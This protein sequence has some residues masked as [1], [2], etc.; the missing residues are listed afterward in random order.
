[1]VQMQ[2]LTAS[3]GGPED[4][5]GRAVAL[6]GNMLVATRSGVAHVFRRFGRSWVE[7]QKLIPSDG[8]SGAFGVAADIRG[9]TIVIGDN[10]T[11]DWTNPVPGAVYI[12][13]WDGTKWVEQ[14]K[15]TLPEVTEGDYFGGSVKISADAIFVGADR[16]DTAG[17]DS[18]AVYMFVWNGIS[19]TEQQKLGASDA[20]AGDLFGCAVDVDGET[21]VIGAR[22]DDTDASNAG[23]AYVFGWNGASWI[24]QHKITGDGHYARFGSS[25]AVQAYT[26]IVGASYQTNAKGSGAGAA[27]IFSWD[28]GAWKL[29]TYLTA[30]NGT[31]YANFGDAVAVDGDGIVVGSPQPYT[32]I[33]P[34][35][36]RGNGAAYFFHRDGSSWAEQE[37]FHPTKVSPSD[38]F[39]AS[40]AMHGN[41]LIVGGDDGSRLGKA[42]IFR[43]DGTDWSP[44][45]KLAASDSD[46]NDNFGA[47]VAIHGG[48]AVV[49]AVD[50]E[51]VYVFCWDGEFWVEQAK[52]T[53]SDAA[54][55]G[56][57]GFGYSV[58]VDGDRIVVGTYG[59]VGAYVYGWDGVSWSEQ[60]K[61]SESVGGAVAINGD[62]IVVGDI[63]NSNENGD[64][65]GA[66]Y[67]F[68]WD[69]SA[70]I[71]EALLKASDGVGMQRFGGAMDIDGDTLLVGSNPYNDARFVYVFERDGSA[72]TER[73]KPTPVDD[74]FDYFHPSVSVSGNLFVVGA[75]G[76]GAAGEDMPGHAYVFEK[77]TTGYQTTILYASDGVAGDAFGSSVAVDGSRVAIGAKNNDKLNL[78]GAGAVYLFDAIPAGDVDGNGSIDLVDAILA[79]QITCGLTPDQPVH[80]A[81]DVSG[82]NHIGLAEAVYV[83]QRVSEFRME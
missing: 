77:S 76:W 45:Q 83:L 61:L 12:F 32:Y 82:E 8:G 34:I 35:V 20:A 27:Y 13:V 17:E 4:R 23:A 41:Q 24:E 73:D 53:S 72:W 30:S 29:H 75:D 28:G 67:V 57:V 80:H 36:Y 71:Q 10:G 14:Q 81:A 58:A 56:N 16:D 78:E 7:E 69:G 33:D 59:G 79:M 68:V 19:W 40:L 49:G 5:F 11:G 26:I 55:T 60:T 44:Q 66:A 65:A 74:S 31:N 3:D 70:W 18:G 2:K 52:L 15:L 39:G 37:C 64:R 38:G 21:L 25:V 63:W 46:V 51:A 48:R 9:D 62:T 6:D 22:G 47:S 54:Q 42:W 1:W 43:W 50:A